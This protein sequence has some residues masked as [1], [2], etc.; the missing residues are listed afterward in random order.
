MDKLLDWHVKTAAK[1]SCL[2]AAG[3]R[4]GDLDTASDPEAAIRCFSQGVFESG[5]YRTYFRS[6]GFK[7]LLTK[8]GRDA[9]IVKKF[10][11]VGMPYDKQATPAQM[12]YIKDEA[13]VLKR[14]NWFISAE[15]LSAIQNMPTS[16]VNMQ[17]C[18][19]DRISQSLANHITTNGTTPFTGWW[20]GKNRENK[21]RMFGCPS[22]GVY[23]PASD[24]F[25]HETGI[26]E[27]ANL[28]APANGASDPF[29][30]VKLRNT[31]KNTYYW[32]RISPDGR[33]V[34]NAADSAIPPHEYD[35]RGFID[36]LAAEGR[37]VV[38]KAY[39][40]P[41]FTPDNEWFMY[42]GAN[43]K[44]KQAAFCRMNT[45]LTQTKIAPVGPLCVLDL[46]A[47]ES[48][49]GL[50]QSIGADPEGGSYVLAQGGW[51]NDNG[52]SPSFTRNPAVK[53]GKNRLK[54]FVF[55]GE[56]ANP[57]QPL[58]FENES[59]WVVA[60]STKLILGRYGEGS[61]QQSGYRIRMLKIK[62]SQDPNS[63]PTI[64][65]QIGA[66]IC[67]REPDTNLPKFR[68][69]KALLSLDDRF[70]AIH[71]FGDSQVVSESKSDIMLYDLLTGQSLQVTNMPTGVYA[72]YPSWRSDGWIYFLVRDRRNNA[73]EDYVAATNAAFWLAGQPPKDGHVVPDAELQH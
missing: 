8:G 52:G 61:S 65:Q 5:L 71:K 62:N 47:E 18:P 35:Y 22:S 34:A 46:L 15:G 45:L 4:R 26:K 32:M 31:P 51:Q 39:Y 28:P 27:I 54:I 6:N 16:S 58:E 17:A 43:G 30:I 60:P 69:G 9:N 57:V 67:E 14:I 7:A 70:I 10:A 12:E 1:F 24:C 68:G 55:D 37:K 64:D 3:Y 13:E 21:L 49:I 56:R 2:Q 38:I 40:D 36:D 33:F 29:R 19:T 25:V 50:Y 73:Q 63:S 41:G 59:D 72:L 48:K 53:E 42:Q 44:D 20:S 23:N 66:E 11:N